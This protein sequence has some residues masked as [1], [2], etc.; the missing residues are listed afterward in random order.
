MGV[1]LSEKLPVGKLDA[2]IAVEKGRIQAIKI[3]GDFSGQKDVAGLEMQLTGLRYDRET[4]EEVL[5]TTDLEPYFGPLDKNTF[6][7]LLSV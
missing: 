7:N 4:L 3:Y 6:L 2:R 5:D 1:E